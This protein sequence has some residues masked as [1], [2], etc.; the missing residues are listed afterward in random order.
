[1]TMQYRRLGRTSLDVSVI[2]LGT[3]TWGEQNTEADAHSQLD[4]ALDQGINFIDTAEMYPVPPR[5]VTQ[6]STEQCIGSWPRLHK[7]RDQVVLATKVS[8]RVNWLPHIRGGPR[9]NK[10][11]IEAAINS[12]LKR[13][14][15]DYI[16]LYQLHF[17]DRVTNNFGA[18][19]Y[20]HKDDDDAVPVEET[21][22]VLTDLIRDGKV[23]YIGISN[24]TP[25]GLMAYLRA[26]RR[27]DDPRIVSIQNPYSLLNRTFEIGLAEC[28][29]RE[30]V[31][32]L[33]YSPLGFGTLSGKYLDGKKPANSRVTLFSR[34]S[35]YTSERAERAVRAY[36][37]LAQKH[38][39]DPS[40]MALAYCNSRDFLT[41][42][43]IGATSMEQLKIDIGS[44]DLQLPEEV[45]KG[46]EAI[47]QRDPNP[48]P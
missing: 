36:V 6:G 10:E 13:L 2:C 47:H 34:F 35:R 48:C 11:H 32:L 39:L 29:I 20:H 1:M 25:W 22:A 21:L 43:I 16:D 12:S 37:E 46:I 7:Y 42:T 31:G 28:A 14:R 8:G 41:S 45:L 23:R 17:P 44:I 26:A 5:A 19:G 33:A 38:G 4:Y 24:E 30:K 40:Q 3:M 27:K 18:L 15:T 9:L